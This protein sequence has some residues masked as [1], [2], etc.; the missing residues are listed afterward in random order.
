MTE[1][2]HDG[3][4]ED[5][6]S[7][8]TVQRVELTIT[9]GAKD[10]L[11]FIK[12][13]EKHK[14][15]GPDK[16]TIKT[17][18][19]IPSR[20]SIER[21]DG[22]RIE[23]E[24]ETKDFQL[25]F[26]TT[27]APG[28][29]MACFRCVIAG[30]VVKVRLGDIKP[31]DWH[32]LADILTKRNADLGL[33]I[34][35]WTPKL[36]QAELVRAERFPV[37]AGFSP[38]HK[39]AQRSRAGLPLFPEESRQF[40]ELRT[41]LNWAVGLALFSRT[42]K[43]NPGGWQEVTVADLTQRV[44]S[45]AERRGDHREDILAEVVK[46]HNTKNAYVRFDWE[47]RG[48][49]WYR[50]VAL[51]SEYAIPSLELIVRDRKTRRLVRPTD[52]AW[53]SLVRPFQVKGRRAYRPNGQDIKTLPSDRFFLDRIRWRWNPSFVED[54]KAEVALDAKGR[55][56]RDASGKVMRGGYYIQ[57]A[58]A[59]FDALSRLRKENA[60]VA[61]D[62]L[63]L[64]A[65]DIYRPKR[66]NAAGRFTVEREAEGLFAR[67]GLEADPK[68]PDRRENSVAAAIFRLKQL[69]IAALLPGSD[70]RPRPPSEAELASGRRKS[71][72]YRL[73]RSALYTPPAALISKEEAAA[74]EVEETEGG[75]E[76]VP[77]ADQAFLPGLQP[78]A[79]PSG[80]DIRAAREN[81]GMNLRD[82]A[83]KMGGPSFKTWSII[84]TRQRSAG[85]G[86]I[87]EE[88]WQRVRDFVAK[89][90]PKPDPGEGKGG[91]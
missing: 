73:I 49:V 37:A 21:P 88:V 23:T 46:L 12:A 56:K 81:A 8:T 45:L 85:A 48:R 66:S 59:I 57:V 9:V 77:P 13:H 35:E 6:K 32:K 36:V 20:V 76:A 18:D 80:A 72:F 2:R 10:L 40:H 29:G 63:V 62:L 90:G 27:F 52:P 26:Q 25:S 75:A 17:T 14:E 84:E 24:G 65:T 67:L 47:R 61:S 30:D 53:R 54:L 34:P 51:G 42:L 22:K 70:E 16:L 44:F 4:T 41:P 71:P 78:P 43:N 33:T 1:E 31:E 11:D 89:Y 69:D 74:L 15:S 39:L 64:L 58:D 3:M 68:H 28:P 50:T 5:G 60:F 38:V 55:V 82:F 79:I 86:R 19:P 91:A 87:P 83:R 7:K